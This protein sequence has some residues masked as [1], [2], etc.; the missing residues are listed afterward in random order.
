M[1]ESFEEPVNTFGFALI[2]SIDFDIHPPSI[3][4]RIYVRSHE[5]L[6]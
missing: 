1:K 6:Y 4:P 5:S 3:V 2:D